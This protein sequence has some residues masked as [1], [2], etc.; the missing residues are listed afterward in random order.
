MTAT[1]PR[2]THFQRAVANRRAHGRPHPSIQPR[3]D[4]G[5]PE[6]LSSF[7]GSGAQIAA[8]A[9]QSRAARLVTLTGGGGVGKTRLAVQ[10]AR[11]VQGEYERCSWLALSSVIDGDGIGDLMASAFHGD[12]RLQKVLIVLD[13]CEHLISACADLVYRLL[14]ECPSLRV[15][16]TSREPLGVPGEVV[17]R[18]EPLSVPDPD[19]PLQEQLQSEAVS[20]FLER[21]RARDA[22]LALSEDACASV[23]GICRALNG[24]P[25]AIE[26]AAGRTG[27]M[28]VAELAAQVDADV[29]GVLAGGPRAVPRRQQGLRASLDWS[30][31]LLQASEQRLL[32]RL[33]VFVEEFTL[34]EAVAAGASEELRDVALV[35]DRL[36]SQSMVEARA[37]GTRTRFRLQPAVRAYAL[38]QL[39][40]TGEI[41]RLAAAH[42]PAVVDGQDVTLG[43]AAHDAPARARRWRPR[44]LSERE[45]DVVVLIASGRSNRQIA[46]D[47]VITK[48]T[49]EAHVSH[50]LTKLGLSSRVQIATW[51]LQHGLVRGGGD[52]VSS[53][54][55]P[56]A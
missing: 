5:L 36:V 30:Y 51:S 32:G 47:L 7:V 22:R 11:A 15:L 13:N 3:S 27:G 14:H 6:D 42:L 46:D 9:A 23:V 2:A 17:C 4:A 39:R 10:V 48:K 56:A 18:V 1:V 55:S 19:A 16:A 26:L 41:E 8:V 31:A 20:L 38:E 54:E 12:L 52:L 43:S 40:A 50:I 35:L 45:R 24:V 25:L 34:D 28:T 21:A 53:A 37:A 44:D 33:N 49:A 29:L